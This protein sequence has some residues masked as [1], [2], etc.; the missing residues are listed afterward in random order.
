M[1]IRIDDL[2]GPEIITLI[3]EHYKEMLSQSPE[4]SMHALDLERLRKPEII[5]WTAWEGKELLGCGAMKELDPTHGEIKSMR[6]APLHT[7]KGVAKRI[8]EHMLE[9]AQRRG[10]HQVSL[11]TGTLD[12]FKPAISLYTKL[13]FEYCEPFADYVE[14]PYSVFMTKQLTMK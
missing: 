2:T 12:S 13:G 3:E 11:E 1:D 8:L 4:D 7:R 14:D 6:T 5:F 10:Y 9:E